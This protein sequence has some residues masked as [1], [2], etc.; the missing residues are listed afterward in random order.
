MV[1]VPLV[2]ASRGGSHVLHLVCVKAGRCQLH[3]HVFDLGCAWVVVLQPYAS[4][5]C[6]S[7]WTNKLITA[8]DFGSVQINIGHL[9]EHGVYTN[10]YTTYAL[11][12]PVRFRVR[13]DC[14]QHHHVHVCSPTQG[15]ADS[16]I[17]KLWTKDRAN[18]GQ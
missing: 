6:H 2:V 8:K 4:L 12:G 14:P 13:G 9:D 11:S 10:S 1:R 16:A 17:D 5:P 7:S 18:I 3:C 15:E